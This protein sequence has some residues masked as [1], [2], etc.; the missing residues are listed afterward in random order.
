MEFQ[1]GNKVMLKV[2]PW[3]GVVSFGKRG[4]LNPR[5]V[6]SFKV[7]ER[8]GD[9]A[10]KLDLP[11]ELRRVHNTFHVSYLKKCHADEPLAVPLDGLHFDDKLHLVEEPVEIM[12]REV[13]SDDLRDALFVLY[14]TSAHLR[15]N[16][17]SGKQL[18]LKYCGTFSSECSPSVASTYSDPLQYEL[19]KLCELKNNIHKFYEVEKLQLKSNHEKELAEVIA[20]MN[21]KYEAKCQDAEAAFQSKKVEIDARFKKVVKNKILA[22]AFRS[23]CP[24]MSPF[25]P[26]VLRVQSGGMQFQ[27]QPSVGGSASSPPAQVLRIP[28]QPSLQI[29][30]Q[31]MSSHHASSPTSQSSTRPPHLSP[32]Q[33]P[34]YLQTNHKGHPTQNS[35]TTQP[36]SS[37]SAAQ[38]SSQSPAASLAL[39]PLYSWHPSEQHPPGSLPAMS[40]SLLETSLP[41]MPSISISNTGLYSASG[42]SFNLHLSAVHQQPNTLPS[43]L[44]FSDVAEFGKEGGSIGPRDPESRRKYPKQQPPPPSA[45]KDDDDGLDD[46]DDDEHGETL[47]GSCGESY[48]SDEFWICCDICERWFHGD[49]VGCIYAKN[50]VLELVACKIQITGSDGGL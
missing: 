33:T 10:Y 20:E 36:F 45:I 38:T 43:L 12:D 13:A 28:Q 39:P 50:L 21:R 25:D 11:K 46:E 2:S 18:E 9:V 49:V 30:R 4:K 26:A 41:P 44:E 19:E 14:L 29:V 23:M 27:G 15:T 8:V 40:S 6:G 34:P 5:Y 47:Y 1:V 22:D 35:P 37:L 3:K 31:M 24:D 16:H 32:L 7:L 48:I 17:A 42:G